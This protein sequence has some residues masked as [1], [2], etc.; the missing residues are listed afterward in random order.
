MNL[1][2]PIDG[3]D[4]EISVTRTGMGLTI[5]PSLPS[6]FVEISG[7]A[8][9][10]VYTDFLRSLTYQHLDFSPGNPSTSESR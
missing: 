2:N 10:T 6:H 4:E 9:K 5:S 1:T 8:P 3:T 7:I